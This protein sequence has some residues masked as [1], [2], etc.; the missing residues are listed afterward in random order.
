MSLAEHSLDRREVS[1]SL[2]AWERQSELSR[3]VHS[4]LRRGEGMTRLQARLV[5][6]AIVLA[7][8]GGATG[9][10]RCRQFVSFSPPNRLL[11]LALKR[12]DTGSRD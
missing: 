9:L 10:S 2:G 11:P 12:R 5:L 6:S 7:L 3:R 4:I 8:L 1:L